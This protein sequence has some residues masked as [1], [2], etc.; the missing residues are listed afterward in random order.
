MLLSHVGAWVG[1][2]PCRPM[3]QI[4]AFGLSGDSMER[5]AEKE[6][7]FASAGFVICVIEFIVYL[8]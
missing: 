3:P 6:K 4:P 2:G 5:V 8:M 7:G 1:R